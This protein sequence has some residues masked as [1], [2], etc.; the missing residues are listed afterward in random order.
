LPFSHNIHRPDLSELKSGLILFQLNY[1]KKMQTNILSSFK[2]QC[3]S[4]IDCPNSVYD[5]C[6]DTYEGV[7]NGYA[8]HSKWVGVD[9]RYSTITS[10]SGE[11]V[12]HCQNGLWVTNELTPDWLMPLGDEHRLQEAERAA[13][14]AA[15]LADRE[16]I[17][18]DTEEL[19]HV[20]WSYH[21][22]RL[23]KH[24]ARLGKSRLAYLV[25]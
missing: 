6:G 5:G 23:I 22:T 9:G 15:E 11:C 1:N 8:Y 17:E 14:I 2:I 16:A 18:R 24:L 4:V 3:T 20:L 13:E 25:R 10:P 19:S 12:A 21:G 7:F